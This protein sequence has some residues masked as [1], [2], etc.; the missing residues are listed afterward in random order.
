[1]WQSTNFVC[2]NQ[3]KAT[4]LNYCIDN[5]RQ[6]W[7]RFDV[8]S[9]TKFFSATGKSHYSGY[10][11]FGK[12]HVL[13]SFLWSCSEFPI[14]QIEFVGNPDKL[15]SFFNVEFEGLLNNNLMVN[16][17]SFLCF[18]AEHVKP[19]GQ[20]RQVYFHLVGIYGINS[21]GHSTI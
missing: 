9:V 3:Y 10:F 2:Q 4:L 18:D 11:H 12:N 21:F 17:L 7:T 16:R 8:S 15:F 19:F 1:M 5:L 13:I 14:F 20:A 6:I